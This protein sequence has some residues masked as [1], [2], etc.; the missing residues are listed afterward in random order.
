MAWYRCGGTPSSVLSLPT[1]SEASGVIAKFNTDLTENLLSAVAEFSASQDLHGQSSPYPAGGGI[2]KWDEEWEVG[3]YNNTTGGKTTETDRIRNKNNII[4]GAGVTLKVVYP[5]NL[6]GGIYVHYWNSNDEHIGVDYAQSGNSSIVTTPENTAYIKFNTQSYYGNTYHNDISINYPSTDT[7]YHPYSNICPIVGV[8]KVNVVDTGKN[9]MDMN[10]LTATGITVTNGEAVGT[11]SSFNAAFGQGAQGLKGKMIFKPNTQYTV[12]VQAYNEG[13]TSTTGNGLWFII[14][15]TDETYTRVQF[16][17]TDTSYSL[18]TVTSSVNKTIDYIAIS[19]GSSGSNIW[20]VKEFQ[21]EQNTEA[22]AYEP[23][24][25]TTA[26]INLGG[27]YYGGW[28][29]AVTGKITL[30]HVYVFSDGTDDTNWSYYSAYGS[31][32]N[33]RY[34]YSGLKASGN[35][36]CNL[37]PKGNVGNDREIVSIAANGN[38]INFE[39]SSS[40]LN[41]NT[42][43]D[44]MTFFANNNVQIVAELATPIVVYAS[45]TAEIPTLNGL[46]Q[47]YADSGDVAVKFLETVGHKI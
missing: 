19:Y 40:R 30:T 9:I 34:A 1:P 22:T 42:V 37:L 4:I 43:A 39:I 45:N 38:Y 18:K 35:I 33:F 7:A 15:Y 25:G 13:N 17:N 20:H 21:V 28:V 24:N 31:S 23:Y 5:T 32:Y 12:S 41:G 47:V 3:G 46:N 2:N 36:I 29:D 14:Y 11:S 6:S 44:L 8:D 16:A 26:L 10:Y 27:T